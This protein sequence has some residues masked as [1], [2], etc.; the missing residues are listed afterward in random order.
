M[1]GDR[2]RHGQLSRLLRV[3]AFSQR[4]EDADEASNAAVG[5]LET[6]GAQSCR[7]ARDPG[8][9]RNTGQTAAPTPA[10]VGDLPLGMPDPYGVVLKRAVR[11]D[12]RFA[13]VQFVAGGLSLPIVHVLPEEQAE[14]R[15]PPRS[16]GTG[17]LEWFTGR[18][19]ADNAPVM[20]SVGPPL[21][22]SPLFGTR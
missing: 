13:K 22:R 8:S 1:V 3:F 17:W 20:A 16:V 12:R 18:K 5:I 15:A 14:M 4:D 9:V 10:G 11:I 19:P 6:G 21:W 7:Q 2:Q